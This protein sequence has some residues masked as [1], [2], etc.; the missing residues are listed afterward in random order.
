MCVISRIDL[1]ISFQK[2]FLLTSVCWI[3]KT[4]ILPS[5]KTS[6]TCPACPGSSR[7]YKRRLEYLSLW[8]S[9]KELFS[10][11]FDISPVQARWESV[12]AHRHWWSQLSILEWS[13][14]ELLRSSQQGHRRPLKCIRQP[15]RS[16][17]EG[18][19][20]KEEQA[21]SHRSVVILQFCLDS[22]DRP[23]FH[24]CHC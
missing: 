5:T 2:N 18:C 9:L 23:I 22:V 3:S 6:A 16:L 17:W 24:V 19:L 11:F 14:S 8:T 20:R 21:F 10:F 7:T 13:P 1:K 15:G 4:W 12:S